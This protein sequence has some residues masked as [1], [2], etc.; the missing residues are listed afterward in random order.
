MSPPLGLRSPSPRG[1]RHSEGRELYAPTRLD[2]HQVGDGYVE[3]VSN[4]PKSREPNV[5]FASLDLS[6][7]PAAQANLG[8]GF[9]L[10]QA[11]RPPCDLDHAPDLLPERFRGLGHALHQT[12][13]ARCNIGSNYVCYSLGGSVMDRVVLAVLIMLGAVACSDGQR[14]GFEKCEA[15]ESQGD[16][17]SA[18][19]ACTEAAAKDRTTKWGE[20]AYAKADRLQSTIK[21]SLEARARDL[22][23]QWTKWEQDLKAGRIPRGTPPP[24]GGR[25]PDGKCNCK[26]GDP[27]CSCL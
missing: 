22:E 17:E 16:L 1:R 3:P 14:K 8:G 13:T 27:L 9:V 12:A 19:K 24:G 26:P 25:T 15:L 21:S 2:I 4:V 5:R 23:E 7:V 18:L 20:L 10:G 11:S 6:E